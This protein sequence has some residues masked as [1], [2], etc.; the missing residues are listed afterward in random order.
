MN[1]LTYVEYVIEIRIRCRGVIQRGLTGARRFRRGL[2]R[3]PLTV[4]RSESHSHVEVVRICG[5]RE[6]ENDLV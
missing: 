4:A 6:N 1:I 3:E 5:D 2:D